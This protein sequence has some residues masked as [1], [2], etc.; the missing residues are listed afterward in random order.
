MSEPPKQKPV[1]SYY[2]EEKN[3]TY[4]MAQTEK[5]A[6]EGV[7]KKCRIEVMNA[8]KEV[9]RVVE[10]GKAHTNGKDHIGL[11]VIQIMLI[12][13]LTIFRSLLSTA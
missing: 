3:V 12:S 5:S 6:L 4:Q 13:G 10:T 1:L 11:K 2:S 9:R 7:I 8:F